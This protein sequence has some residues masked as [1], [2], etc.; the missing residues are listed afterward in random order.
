MPGPRIVVT[1]LIAQYPLGGVAWDYVQYI[2]G[3]ARLGY[4]AYYIEDTGAWPYNPDEGGVS[5]GCEYNVRYLD[6]VMKRFGLGERWAYCFAHERQWFGLSDTKRKEVLA[7][8]DLLLNI[9]GTLWAPPNYRS[10]KTLAYIDSDPTFTQVKLARGETSLITLMGQHDV[11][12]S[13]GE[14]LPGNTPK[15]N[16][17]WIPTRQPMLIDEWHPIEER[18][19]IFTTVMNWT[20]ARPIE[21]D[22]VR[23]GQKDIEF[24]RF[25]DLPPRVAPTE[26][27]L[28]VNLG[29][30]NRTPYD[31]LRHKGWRLA[32]PD[33]VCPDIDSYRRYLSTSKA[34]WSVAKNGYVVGKSGWFSCRSACYLA[35]GRPVAVEDT[36]F[37]A[38]IPTGRGVLAFFDMDGAVAAIRDI[39]AS[40]DMHARAARDIAVEYFDSAKVLR[41]LV[42]AALS[43]R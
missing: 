1:G 3:L 24:Q 11:H 36:G 43:G 28:A 2:A 17:D 32:D 30:T 6:G 29:K 5:K 19:E 14:A 13:F 21:H 40:Y 20:T 9:S 22:G 33:V 16:I 34:E 27:E 7:T 12:F 25:I 18:R 8:A 26:I 4:D 39:E 10:I 23:Y 41:K 38:V 15:T 42:D 31:L 35:A 37:G